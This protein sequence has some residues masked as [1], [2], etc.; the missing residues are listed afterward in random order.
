MAK[1]CLVFFTHSLVVHM[2][3]NTDECALRQTA[4]LFLAYRGRKKQ[5]SRSYSVN[6]TNEQHDFYTKNV[7][8]HGNKNLSLCILL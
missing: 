6:D 5:L 2:Y 7:S 4:I 3:S 8:M 1:V